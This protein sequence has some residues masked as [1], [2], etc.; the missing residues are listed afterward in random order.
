MDNQQDNIE[1]NISITMPGDRQCLQ[2]ARRRLRVCEACGSSSPAPCEERERRRRNEKKTKKE[3]Q[4]NRR[5]RKK[6][7]TK[8][9]K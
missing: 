4:K 9:E 7:K 1:I 2:T 6:K 5:R 8:K 3:E